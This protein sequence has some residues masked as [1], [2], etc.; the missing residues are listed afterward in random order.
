[1]SKTDVIRLRHMLD[2]AQK[3][4]EFTKGRTR[5]DLDTDE[6]L[7]LA[8]VRLLEM[9]GEAAKAVSE[10]TRRQAPDIVWKQV[11][12]TRDR[13]I[14]SYFDVDLNIVWEIVTQDLPPLVTA[15]ER[16]ISSL[17]GGV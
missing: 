16:L 6:K 8:I 4:V 15:L 9:L 1:M 14:H 17:R 11:A 5:V 7:S 13:L 12:G 2:A 3:A 10:E